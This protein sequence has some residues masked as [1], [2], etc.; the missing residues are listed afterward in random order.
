MRKISRETGINKGLVRR[1]AKEELNF[2]AY[3]LQNIQCLTDYNKRVRLQRCRQLKLWAAIQRWERILLTDE[4][5]FTLEK[6]QGHQSDRIWVA[7]APDISAIM[8]HGQNSDSVMAW[9]EIYNRGE[10]PL[11]FVDQQKSTSAT[12]S[13]PLCFFG[14]SSTSSIKLE[15]SIGLRAR[16]IDI[17]GAVL[18]QDP[19]F[20]LRLVGGMVALLTGPQSDELQPVFLTFKSGSVLSFTK[21]GWHLSYRCVG[22]GIDYH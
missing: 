15:A 21:V 13:S 4:K 17:N 8:E 6:A 16:S 9:G 12:F 14:L 18:V 22:F 7:E 2:K 19:F 10:T 1:M 11:V 3:K 5:L 20:R